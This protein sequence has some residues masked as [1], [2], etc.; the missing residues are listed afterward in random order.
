[1]KNVMDES[2]GI[3]ETMGSAKK[4]IDNFVTTFGKSYRVNAEGM[5][6]VAGGLASAR[7]EQ[8]QFGSFDAREKA[9]A[10]NT[11]VLDKSTQNLTEAQIANMNSRDAMQSFVQKGVAPAT[12]AL[13]ALAQ[14][15]SKLAGGAAAAVGAPPG[16]AASGGSGGSGGGGPSLMRK[17]GMAIGAVGAGPGS[18]GGGGGGGGV[19]GGAAPSG[20]EPHDSPVG[21]GGRGIG[22]KPKLVRVSSKTGKSAEVNSEYASK[23]QGVIDYLD[24]VGYNIY[25]LGGYVDRD[26]RGQP[27]RKSVHAHGGAIDINP[28]ENPLGSQLVT[29]MPAEIGKIAAQLGLGWGGNW[30][31]V[32]DAMHFSVAQNEGGTIKLSDGGI[33]SGPTSGYSATLHGTEAVVPL[34]NGKTIPVEMAGFSTSLTDQTS[35]MSQQLDK[36]DELV[37]VMQNQVSVSTKILQAA[38]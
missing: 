23:F 38:N 6:E 32:K 13:N 3:G 21:A 28:A 17:L 27:G 20:P 11:Q 24:G 14:G 5:R 36:L 18:D 12:A 1:M 15:A 10:R 34:P 19:G 29:D 33:A 30:R 9:A 4:D 35:L 22:G 2:V 25:S 37:R 16:G 26:V 8:L 31:S 7:E